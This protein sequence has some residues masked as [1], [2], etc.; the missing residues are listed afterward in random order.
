MYNA[1]LLNRDQIDNNKWEDFIDRSANGIVYFHT[2]FLDAVCP[3]WKSVI[4]EESGNWL[5]VMP[6]PL[7]KKYF[8]S[9]SLQPMYCKYLGIISGLLTDKLP[10]ET[11][12]LRQN[13]WMRALLDKIPASLKYINWSLLDM[14]IPFRMLSDRNYTIVP[15][16]SYTLS[17]KDATIKYSSNITNHIRKALKNGL[18]VSESSN[19]EPLIALCNQRQIMNQ[20]GTRVFRNLWQSIRSYNKGRYF[21]VVNNNGSL[22]CGAVCVSHG[23]K[24]FMILSAID[25]QYRQ[26][27]A[28]SL[29]LSEVINTYRNENAA[30]FYFEGSM[31]SNVAN[32]LKGFKP[33]TIIYYNVTKS[34]IPFARNLMLLKERLLANTA[35]AL[36]E[37]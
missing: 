23:D 2:W 4:L 14:N 10:D 26:Y 34:R 24:V 15:R 29:L 12:S 20:K 25:Q 16:F 6:L 28:N 21:S 22:L 3:G 17:L 8:M 27:G 19:P 9:Y 18:H 36:M 13:E 35:L 5:A 33:E 37:Q 7:T 32:F 11:P 31:Y 30:Y 1:I